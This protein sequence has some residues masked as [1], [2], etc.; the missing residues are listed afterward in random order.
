MNRHIFSFAL[1][2]ILFC[3][4][5]AGLADSAHAQVRESSPEVLKKFSPQFHEEFVREIRRVVN[6][7]PTE[8]KVGTFFHTNTLLS[9]AH[10]QANSGD[11]AGAAES[12]RLAAHTVL[13]RNEDFG[14]LMND[15]FVLCD[16]PIWMKK[17]PI[18]EGIIAEMQAEENVSKNP[19]LFGGIADWAK[20]Y[21]LI[22]DEN[23][24]AAEQ[25]L[26]QIAEKIIANINEQ[27]Q[28]ENIQKEKQAEQIMLASITAAAYCKV[29]KGEKGAKLLELLRDKIG[30]QQGKIAV[31]IVINHIESGMFEQAKFELAKD[32]GKAFE[33]LKEDYYK[34]LLSAQCA[35]DLLDAAIETANNI[36]K[37]ENP[38]GQ[39]YQEYKAAIASLQTK[40]GKFDAALKTAE[41]SKG[42]IK[43]QCYLTIL[44]RCVK[45]SD[46]QN[47]E[48][49]FELVFKESEN[50]PG[51]WHFGDELT[52]QT[53]FEGL[54]AI[55][56]VL[57]DLK[58][59]TDED[60]ITKT[61][62]EHAKVANPAEF[63]EHQKKWLG[64]VIDAMFAQLEKIDSQKG[65]E[66]SKLDSRLTLFNK[67]YKFDPKDKRISVLQS[68]IIDGILGIADQKDRDRLLGNYVFYLGNMREP[69]ELLLLAACCE[70]PR[71]KIG[72]Y[73]AACRTQILCEQYRQAEDSMRKSL[74]LLKDIPGDYDRIRSTWGLVRIM[75]QYLGREI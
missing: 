63:D 7:T 3:G 70:S 34:Q 71:E 62:S 66:T 51:R 52:N 9:L 47:A 61:G 38:D 41:S 30:N 29:G 43:H 5:F 68:E 45:N 74:H 64:K 23:N 49:A 4:F 11:E 15:L 75:S 35:K 50:Y 13:T 60:E 59:N 67:L 19:F 69:G 12:A 21:K 6:E 22:Y 55:A 1:F 16:F 28:D 54:D 33:E 14:D 37:V 58:N 18:L 40:L 8:G 31:R 27:T 10:Y 25:I 44:S 65:L 73:T 56:D 72:A 26:V 32:N 17:K 53:V 20:A 39:Y 2:G 42:W 57:I 24:E 48:T 46:W 36:E